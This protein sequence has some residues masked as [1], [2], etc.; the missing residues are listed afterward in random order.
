MSALLSWVQ[1]ATF[2]FIALTFFVYY[3]QLRAMRE[4]SKA[5]NVLSVIN[6]L[7]AP[8]VREA[9]R[10]LLTDLV[11]KPLS[12]WDENER[13]LASLVYSTYD[14]AGMLIEGGIVPADLFIE[15]WGPS[16]VL[17]HDALGPY[18]EELSSGVPGARYG[19]HLRWLREQVPET[20]S[21]QDT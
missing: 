2:I 8:D 20:A 17:C 4:A 12:S 10:V 5:E 11:W 3:F 13:A 16:I 15:N 19:C 18:L 9:R 7:Q 14:T 1:V 6:L 21:P